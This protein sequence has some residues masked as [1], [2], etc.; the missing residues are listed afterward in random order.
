MNLLRFLFSQSF[1]YNKILA[2]Q[3][4]LLILNLL[5][6]FCCLFNTGSPMI[7]YT[8]IQ[9]FVARKAVPDFGY[10]ILDARPWILI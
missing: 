6:N 2:N 3:I 8:R 4:I 5:P 7:G 9:R 1:K 10:S